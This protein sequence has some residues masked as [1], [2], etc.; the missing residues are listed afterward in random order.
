MR[1]ALHIF[2]KDVRHLRL[3]IAAVLVLV[4]AF[5]YTGATRVILFDSGWGITW[6]PLQLLL[7]LAWWALIARVVHAEP[8]PGDRQ[9]WLTRP[10]RWKSLLAAKAL[11]I[12][13]FVNMPVVLADAA[14]LRAHGFHLGAQLPGFLWSQVLLTAVFLLPAAVLA[15]L[16]TGTVQWLLTVIAAAVLKVIWNLMMARFN[17]DTPWVQLDWVRFYGTWAVLTAAAVGVLIWQY[18]RRRTAAA[19]LFVAAALAVVTVGSG[20][21]PWTAAFALQSRVIRPRIDSSSLSVGFNSGL[22]WTARALVKNDGQVHIDLPLQIRGVPADTDVHPDGLSVTIEGADGATWRADREPR[23]YVTTIGQ[24]VALETDVA[25]SFYAMVKDKPATLRGSLY[26]TLWGNPRRTIIPLN[27]R[28]LPV[29]GVGVCS[30]TSGANERSYFLLCSAAFGSQPARASVELVQSATEPSPRS[31]RLGIDQPTT[32]YSPF[33]A[34]L[35]INPVWETALPIQEL[36]D[37]EVNLRRQPSPPP[38]KRP[39]AAL[40]HTVERVAHLRRDFVIRDLRL[41]D[42]E[43]HVPAV[44]PL[45]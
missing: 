35:A 17:L 36:P 2:G 6:Q 27:N 32:T 29:P 12:I 25:G 43:A 33:P 10:Y 21:I 30:A 1:Q 3:E 23:R 45:E 5:A 26:L 22:A 8:L 16:T 19:W 44:K 11:F 31:V 20:L 9:F 28:P 13:V 39:T 37:A 24:L 41:A 18:A 40:V 4:A 42:F 34:G 14:I 7:L 15:V 38:S